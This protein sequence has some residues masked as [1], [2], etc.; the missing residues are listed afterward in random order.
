MLD[1]IYFQLRLR[2]PD[3]AAERWRHAGLL[4]TY[5]AYR[6]FVATFA[7][8]ADSLIKIAE[9]DPQNLVEAGLVEPFGGID[10]DEAVREWADR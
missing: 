5:D 9:P 10:V 2:F 8:Y 6:E 1:G 7:D 3:A 4:P